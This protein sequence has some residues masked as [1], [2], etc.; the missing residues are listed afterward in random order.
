LIEEGGRV[1]LAGG[2]LDTQFVNIDG[3]ILQ[4]NGEVF[5][6]T[7]PIRSPVRNLSGRVEPGTSLGGL[8]SIDGDFSNQALGT[9]AID[10][11]GTATSAYDVLDVTRFAFLAG[12]LEVSLTGGFV[13]SDGD[14]FTILTTGAGLSGTFDTLLLPS[15]YQWDVSYG[16]YDLVLEVLGTSLIGDYNDDGV[17]DGADY[18]VWRDTFGEEVDFTAWRSNFGMTSNNGSGSLGSGQAAVPEPTT[19]GLLLVA[20]FVGTLSRTRVMP[21]ALSPR[22][23]QGQWH[24]DPK[25]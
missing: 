20:V 21:V 8:L 24:P 1:E 15:E 4:G 17:V 18:T 23:W 22:Q 6:G 11:S 12:T 9:L 10:L 19:L 13:P 14:I 3:G 7:G 16:Q 5:A 2:K 25:A